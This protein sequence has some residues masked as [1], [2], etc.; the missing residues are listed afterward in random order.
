[1]TQPSKGYLN[2]ELRDL[3]GAKLTSLRKDLIVTPLQSQSYL[4]VPIKTLLNGRGAKTVM[5]YCEFVSDGKVISTNEYFFEPFKNLLL[6]TAQINFD[7]AESSEWVQ[8]NFD[9]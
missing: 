3:D 9:D 1:M 8:G 7:V 6:P 2:V 5:V 4:S